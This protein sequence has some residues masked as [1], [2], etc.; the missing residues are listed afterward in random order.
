LAGGG[1]LGLNSAAWI[2]SAAAAQ[3]PCTH[4]GNTG[5]LQVELMHHLADSSLYPFAAASGPKGGHPATVVA[6]GQRAGLEGK[7]KDFA[8]ASSYGPRSILILLIT[9]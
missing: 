3:T 4:Q 9:K 7:P 1:R 5:S 2:N 6:P 8:G